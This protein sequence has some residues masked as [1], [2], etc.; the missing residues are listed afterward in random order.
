MC[1]SVGEDTECMHACSVHKDVK[2]HSAFVH[3]C[4][5]VMEIISLE[6]K[7]QINTTP[8]ARAWA[9]EIA[10]CGKVLRGRMEWTWSSVSLEPSEKVMVALKGKRVHC[11][12][13]AIR[14]ITPGIDHAPDSG[15]PA[16]CDTKA[17][18]LALL[19]LLISS[20]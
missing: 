8:K 7:R 15:P 12:G 1:V 4:I 2:L 6:G 18:Y 11:R 14:N 9:G 13:R 17:F 19:V 16:L 3:S 5:A 20:L 10:L